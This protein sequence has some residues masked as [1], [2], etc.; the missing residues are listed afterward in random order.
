MGK[1]AIFVVSEKG[2]V[3]KSTVAKALLDHLRRIP[4]AGNEEPSHVLAFDL[5]PKINQLG[6][7]YGLKNVDANGKE[8]YS[9]SLN[10]MS[11][12][13]GV[14]SAS[15]EDDNGREIVGDSIES[16]ADFLLYD[17]PGGKSDNLKEV[18]GKLSTLI[19][20]IKVAGYDIVVVMVLSFLKASAAEVGEAVAVWGEDA[21]YVAVLNLGLAEREQFIFFDGERADQ[22]GYPAKRLEEVGGV[23]IEMPKL[24]A[25]T[26]AEL[27][28]DEIS[29]S[30]AASS[31]GPYKRTKRVR[32]QDWLEVMDSEIA[33]IGLEKYSVDSLKAFEAAQQK[34]ASK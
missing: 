19:T 8:T 23:V 4:A 5:Q 28:A 2:G 25:S 17:L 7:A 29:F 6:N 14:I 33:K 9:S 13:M 12:F 26:Y 20:Q 10:K 30:L 27:D 1:K 22:V 24:Q 11:P 3:G 18:F 34:K 21:R 31:G 16:N 15:L 32:V